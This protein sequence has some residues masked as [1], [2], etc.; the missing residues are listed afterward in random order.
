MEIIL[1]EIIQ[2]YLGDLTQMS[3][4]CSIYDDCNRNKWNFCPDK[5]VVSNT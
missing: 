1:T 3:F 5:T 4:T 2:I